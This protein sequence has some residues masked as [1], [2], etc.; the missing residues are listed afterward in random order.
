[1]DRTNDSKETS[2]PLRRIITLLL[3]LVILLEPVGNL[4]FA[5]SNDS[6]ATSILEEE[7]PITSAP[8]T[9]AP[10]TEE[11]PTKEAPRTQTVEKSFTPETVKP[12][13]SQEV[14]ITTA[15]VTT[16][17]AKEETITTAPVDALPAEEAT[18]QEEVP[19]EEKV[20]DITMALVGDLP[21]S[22]A[23][24]TLRKDGMPFLDGRL[25]ALD[26]EAHFENLAPGA[27]TAELYYKNLRGEE[28]YRTKDILLDGSRE[29]LTERMG[30]GMLLM[31]ED[32]IYIDPLYVDDV[33]LPTPQGERHFS[34]EVIRQEGGLAVKAHRLD[35]READATIELLPAGSLGETENAPATEGGAVEAPIS[36]YT[37]D[38]PTDTPVK[39]TRRSLASPFLMD[40]LE[41]LMAMEAPMA[42]PASEP[43]SFRLENTRDLTA[44][45]AVPEES[46]ST[47]LFLQTVA[48]DPNAAFRES[49][50]R[51]APLTMN[52]TRVA[53]PSSMERAV[54][55]TGTWEVQPSRGSGNREMQYN[56]GYADPVHTIEETSDGLLW[57]IKFYAHAG[58]R[59]RN[60]DLTLVPTGVQITSVTGTW[61][62][63]SSNRSVRASGNTYTM[64]ASDMGLYVYIVKTTKP[65][66][67][68]ASL[69]LTGNVY[70]TGLFG[71]RTTH[72]T[73]TDTFEIRR[74]T[75]SQPQQ[76]TVQVQVSGDA[77]LNGKQVQIT[78][79]DSGGSPV[80]GGNVTETFT[81]GRAAYTLGDLPLG[82]YTV[83][84]Q[85]EGMT[86]NPPSQ[87][88]EVRA[89]QI[90]SANF[91]AKA[92]SPQRG[93]ANLIL[94][95]PGSLAGQ[96]V[97][98]RFYGPMGAQVNDTIRLDASGRTVYNKNQSVPTS[99]TVTP[100]YELTSLPTGYVTS[101]GLTKKELTVPGEVEFTLVGRQS[102]QGDATIV[103]QYPPELQ[104][105]TQRVWMTGPKGAVKYHD[106]VLNGTGGT[107]VYTVHNTPA[108]TF[109][110]EM[111]KVALPKGY[112]VEGMTGDVLKK[113]ATVPGQ[114]HFTIVKDEGTTLDKRMTVYVTRRGVPVGQDG[115][116]SVR[117]D[118]NAPK[119]SRLSSTS[120]ANFTGKF[121]EGK[122]YTLTYTSGH[123]T[124]TARATYHEGQRIHL[125]LDPDNVPKD[126]LQRLTVEVKYND[127]K[128]PAQYVDI[129]VQ[130][131]DGTPVLG[132]DGRPLTGR[133]NTLGIAEFYSVPLN[134][135]STYKAVVTKAPAGYS[136]NAQTFKWR[137]PTQTQAGAI[138]YLPKGEK[139][140][141]IAH[142]Y[143]GEDTSAV[144]AGAE[145][146]I[147]YASTGAYVKDA[148]G[149]DLVLITDAQGIGR[150]FAP[151]MDAGTYIIENTKAPAGFKKA[152]NREMRLT[153][154]SSTMEF[155]Q[156]FLRDRGDGSITWE[157]TAQDRAGVPIGGIPLSYKVWQ[158]GRWVDYSKNVLGDNTTNYNGTSYI[159]GMSLG[160][161]QVSFA[162]NSDWKMGVADADITGEENPVKTPLILSPKEGHGR[163]SIA[164]VDAEGKPVPGGGYKILDERKRVVAQGTTNTTEG[165]GLASHI[166]PFGTY[167]VIGENSMGANLAPGEERERSVVLRENQ[168]AH[169]ETIVFEASRFSLDNN[170][171]SISVDG[172]ILGTEP[173]SKAEW[174]VITKK[175]AS[176]NGSNRGIKTTI[177]FSPNEMLEPSLPKVYQRVNAPD[178]M[179]PD[180]GWEEI[181]T[182][183]RWEAYS[184]Q[185]RFVDDRSNPKNRDKVEYKYVFTAT[186]TD[187]AET[188]TVN[189]T[190]DLSTD[191]INEIAPP[192]TGSLTLDG[193]NVA[194]EAKLGATGS[195][196]PADDFGVIPW[197]YHGTVDTQGPGKVVLSI[198]LP[199]NSGQKPLSQNQAPHLVKV[200]RR[201]DSGSLET[202]EI[203]PTYTFEDGV[204]KVSMDLPEKG[205][206]QFD[207]T[208]QTTVDAAQTIEGDYPLE[209]TLGFWPQ[210]YVQEEPIKR[211]DLNIFAPAMTD[212]PGK[213]VEIESSCPRSPFRISLH[214]QLSGDKR[215][216][217]W[218]ARFTNLAT[219]E[220]IGNISLSE[221]HRIPR[222]LLEVGEGLGDAK[223]TNVTG[224]GESF[225][226]VMLG[227]A[228]INKKEA[229]PNGLPWVSDQEGRNGAGKTF[230]LR[231]DWMGSPYNGE[232]YG[233]SATGE[234]PQGSK[235]L[236]GYMSVQNRSWVRDRGTS[237][238]KEYVNF[239]GLNIL[240]ASMALQRL[241]NSEYIE[242]QF[243]TPITDFSLANK[244]GY[245]I[246]A[247][248][249]NY[250]NPVIQDN[251]SRG[252]TPDCKED[253]ELTIK[254]EL[255]QVDTKEALIE[256]RLDYPDYTDRD[257]RDSTPITGTIGAT[258]RYID[259]PT[260]PTGKA[261]E[262]TV[263]TSHA[264]RAS[265]NG[266]IVDLK[267]DQR[268]DTLYELIDEEG[269]KDTGLGPIK[270][271][272]PQHN[273][274]IAHRNQSGKSTYYEAEAR[275][276]GGRTTLD[277]GMS[278]DK[279]THTFVTPVLEEKD[280]YYLKVRGE[281][282][283]RN[284]GG[285]AQSQ[286]GTHKPQISKDGVP[287]ETQEAV[288]EVPGLKRTVR[289]EKRWTN[290]WDGEQKPD[291]RLQLSRRPQTGGAMEIVAEKIVPGSAAD[292]ARITFENQD[293]IAGGT[294]YASFDENGF[295]YTYSVSEIPVEG[296]EAPVVARLNLE[297]TSWL[298][299]NN[300]LESKDP[301]GWTP[302]YT[303]DGEGT[304]P[305]DYRQDGPDIRNYK[306]PLDETPLDNEHKPSGAN[307]GEPYKVNY[308]D[309]KL[310][311]SGQQTARPGKFD[312]LLTAEGRSKFGSG[313]VD[314][315]FVLD[316]SNS[317]QKKWDAPEG[318][319]GKVRSMNQIVRELT[320]EILYPRNPDGTLDRT[321]TTGNRVGIT[322][323]GVETLA[324]SN[325]ANVLGAGRRYTYPTDGPNTSSTYD[326]I[327]NGEYAK[328]Y[329]PLT[330]DINALSQ[331]FPL[332]GRS[333]INPGNSMRP[334]ENGRIN[335]YTR[336]D[337]LTNMMAGLSNGM[338]LLYPG[339]EKNYLGA[340]LQAGEDDSKREK[341][342]IFISD[343]APTASLKL[344]RYNLDPAKDLESQLVVTNPSG[345]NLEA[346]TVIATNTVP[347]LSNSLKYTTEDGVRI[348][349]NLQ[350]T[351]ALVDYYKKRHPDMTAYT[352]GVDWDSAKFQEGTT[353]E[354]MRMV[355]AALATSPEYDVEAQN[356]QQLR[357]FVDLFKEQFQGNSVVDGT[358]IDPMGAMVNL[359][360]SNGSNPET[361]TIRL[362]TAYSKD[363]NDDDVL[364]NG[365]FWIEDNRGYHLENS[366]NGF[367]V[368][369]ARGN[370]DTRRQSL[371][372]YTDGRVSVPSL[373]VGEDGKPVFKLEG[374]NLA[375]GDEIK[376]RYH[377]HLDTDHPSFVGGTYYQANQ[378]TTLE[379]DPKNYPGILRDFPVPSVKAPV[380]PMQIK[381]LWKLGN[382]V[383]VP[384]VDDEILKDLS[385]TFALKRYRV[386]QP[387]D[388]YRREIPADKTQFDALIRQNILIPDPEEALDTVTLR[389]DNDFSFSHDRL[390]A[391]NSEG[392]EYVYRYEERTVSAPNWVEEKTEYKAYTKDKEYTMVTSGMEYSKKEG[393]VFYATTGGL[394]KCPDV[395][396]FETVVTN[397]KDEDSGRGGFQIRKVD[398]ATGEVMRNIQFDLYAYEDF[399][400]RAK[401]P[402]TGTRPKVMRNTDQNG[403]A[404]FHSLEY[405]TYVLWENREELKKNYPGY[406]PVHGY[407][408]VTIRKSKNPS[409]GGKIPFEVVMS[410]PEGE[411]LT[412]SLDG[413]PVSDNGV[414]S[415]KYEFTVENVKPNIPNTGG[416][417]FSPTAVAM[418]L[419]I[420][421]ACAYVYKVNREEGADE[422]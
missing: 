48:Q 311:K 372:Y 124:K 349:G 228:V 396:G 3:A 331:S 202:L 27:Y 249:Y 157:I 251:L 105:K 59:N 62:A 282:Y 336:L 50:Y 373:S 155:W 262:W 84:V 24:I 367:V 350:P 187:N 286:R 387:Y 346:K 267:K 74:Q 241:M 134:A 229:T 70:T 227:D 340:T 207:V 79:K 268:I 403:R 285:N 184:G 111:R 178:G 223:I 218:S 276:D 180:E 116:V 386:Y 291:I 243:E 320:E 179:G 213:R 233:G 364:T 115:T 171:G 22:G 114:V 385:A 357:N 352:I 204:W 355:N 159:D 312:M 378:R 153:N 64:D 26:R 417:G 371:F 112:S 11:A 123:T 52:I 47:N 335:F 413:Q 192:I 71:S 309:T 206:Y 274:E 120:T 415:P 23:T 361:G 308:E 203:T 39:R 199:E 337:S 416:L 398:A 38:A 302:E 244:T 284:I 342:L 358:I 395:E 293:W 253:G 122:E 156:G 147:K 266:I 270:Q 31:G 400:F 269:L 164:S 36:L 258:G 191:R 222:L 151:S 299:Q 37:T 12:A 324:Y 46:S 219:G 51:S 369:D 60:I 56:S 392:H 96:S 93:H 246:R 194:A 260:S 29:R 381:K 143:A 5:A 21:A 195:G 295:P 318:K 99:G 300:K 390:L 279:I 132:S 209:T 360:L 325:R 298:I 77:S 67:D 237:N 73:I 210:G 297:G 18:P 221:S 110:Y 89:D 289:L 170:V 344:R 55:S 259:D 186:T 35:G 10:V 277:K 414:F 406:V 121:T 34:L 28:V 49:T 127:T 391:Y 108:G 149:N 150:G 380:K 292:S 250:Y 94:N 119:T 315:V 271:T 388:Q 139:G 197:N 330:T 305:K 126:L 118:Q 128:R 185:Y 161:Y 220:G 163:L 389:A 16:V 334:Q 382:R 103:I 301:T 17:P 44:S 80:D 90:V 343:G 138:I 43:A 101:D 181:P 173:G 82:R 412:P 85:A 32:E 247:H 421:L 208:M 316:N 65:T 231:T 319:V 338:S 328:P 394:E 275:Q 193:K 154:T 97:G 91:T 418:G 402:K 140:V 303:R 339:S 368:K 313:N 146:K 100:A 327:G 230:E 370:P 226:Y 141:I 117:D 68:R 168:D 109:S 399:D 321:R 419:G 107:K 401:A 87:S 326:L 176:P 75:P 30:T 217:Q 288:V 177:T 384:G 236:Y 224:T 15:P 283:H 214:G 190:A 365:D 142:A 379:P 188:Y 408:I 198:K 1:M 189:A 133:T 145:F 397:K 33:I 374:V 172:K 393:T 106:V 175:E 252:D 131:L 278:P 165:T 40:P 306:T 238:E 7:A 81:N 272:T 66:G 102:T 9:T 329:T 245:T 196:S 78:V 144:L 160:T 354:E 4:V 104:G 347:F 92:T 353:E 216:I 174:T 242:V 281:I 130:N 45:L 410:T 376:I 129:A 182:T 307:Q 310:G 98:I 200:Q 255:M 6:R 183:G 225:P 211:A 264:D 363:R 69:G 375:K 125:E 265:H 407:Y 304:Y 169:K 287:S 152:P 201:T 136:V 162:G 263:T 95:Y 86:I 317:M 256:L 257:V 8:I 333:R 57:K 348:E 13:E 63:N 273:G 294:P 239:Y 411:R 345:D 362:A 341:I 83:E 19:V 332:N 322:N 205:N 254:T 25:G 314:V 323:F 261:I 148:N 232:T 61:G 366:G 383:L 215:S 290:V 377:I 359:D 42:E 158:N 135:G 404:M 296:Y 2:R 58:R 234:P 409:G 53:S 212:L 351:L 41:S 88:V 137:G 76:G 422:A 72:A 280:A 420:L 405:G 167:K 54:R 113:S 166:L 356:Y 20:T 240:S 235:N 14:P 248:G